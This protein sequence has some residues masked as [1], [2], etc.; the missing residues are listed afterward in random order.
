MVPQYTMILDPNMHLA[1]AKTP[2]PETHLPEMGK[3][4]L[5][6]ETVAYWA[7]TPFAVV[8]N[9]GDGTAV[10]AR[11]GPINALE[12]RRLEK[13]TGAM[14]ETILSAAAPML[15]AL[16]RP[17]LLLPGPLQVVCKAQR[18]FLQ[19]NEVYEGVWHVDGDG[20][21]VVAVIL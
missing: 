2:G 20:E 10:A 15:A 21:N 8:P 9:G 11:L 18:I 17:S 19:P 16:R 6:S 7:A 3:D 13:R 4:K 14:V 5:N 12:D 1:E